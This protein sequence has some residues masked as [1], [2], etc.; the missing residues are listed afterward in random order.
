MLY[1]IT[2]AVIILCFIVSVFAIIRCLLR[3]R[4]IDERIDA[5]IAQETRQNT[6]IEILERRE[7][8]RQAEQQQINA[9]DLFK[10]F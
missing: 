5:I 3:I 10:P 8:Q 6:K 2:N 9:R 7:R 4:D 1:G